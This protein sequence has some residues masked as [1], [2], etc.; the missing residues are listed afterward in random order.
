M[1]SF[2]EVVK[3]DFNITTTA[4][5]LYTSQ[6]TVSKQLKMLEDELNVE[7]FIRKNNKLIALSNEGKKIYDI[8]SDILYQL[9]KIKNITSDENVGK[10]TELH[11]AT[12]HT[13][14]RYNLPNV[15]ERFK[16]KYPNIALHFHQ[17]APAQI[18]EMIKNGDVDFAIATEAMYLYEDLITIPCYCWTRSIIVPHEHPLAK[19]EE[20][21]TIHQLASYPLITYVFG[22][23]GQSKLDKV[24]TEY[25][26]KPNIS[27]TAT[28]T[29]IIKHYVRRGMGIG[30]IAT[31]AF[32]EEDKIDLC[33]I[34]IDHIVQPSYTHICLNKHKRLNNCMYE[35]ISLYA[36]HVDKNMIQLAERNKR[37]KF[38]EHVYQ[39]L[40]SL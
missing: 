9:I 15:I 37:N 18:S 40:P 21:V 20:R 19:L 7:L 13:Q 12:T 8:V 33:C 11:I 2:F 22:F 28:D 10:V 5:K 34:N 38:D 3:N 23:N 39:A 29:D 4:E 30:V 6:S 25:K 31:T 35:F 14:I 24:F 16:N 26:I 32:S 36:P 1:K 17:G 27:L